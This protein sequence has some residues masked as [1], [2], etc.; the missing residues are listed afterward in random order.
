MRTLIYQ[1]FGVLLSL[2]EEG[3]EQRFCAYGFQSKQAQL[4]ELAGKLAAL[5]AIPL[6]EPDTTGSNLL[7][8]LCSKRSTYPVKI[9][10]PG[11]RGFVI[12]WPGQRCLL[13][14]TLDELKLL[15]AVWVI[16][17]STAQQRFLR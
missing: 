12:D 13:N 6:P 10:G 4:Q 9:S 16:G 2:Q 14:S 15:Y 7:A 1:E 8:L 3:I 17:R 11:L 5:M